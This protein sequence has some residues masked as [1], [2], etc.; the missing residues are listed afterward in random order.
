MPNLKIALDGS[1]ML[2]VK[3]GVYQYV[4]NL[5]HSLRHLDAEFELNYFLGT[6][7]SKNLPDL[8]N[9]IHTSNLYKLI[10]SSFNVFGEPGKL[11][12]KNIN[13]IFQK[14]I[15]HRGIKNINPHI[16]HFTDNYI[17]ISDIPTVYTFYDLS[18]FRFPET[19]PY[20]RVVWQEKQLPKALEQ[21]S[22]IIAISEFSKNELV[23]Y[24]GIN[25]D[26]I[27]VIYCGVNESFYPL[28]KEEV[29]TT[30]NNFSLQYKKYILSLGTIEPRKNLETIIQAYTKLPQSIQ[31]CYKMVIVGAYG[32]KQ[33]NILKKYSNLIDSGNLVI[34]GYMDQKFLPSIISGAAL[35]AYPS[36]YEGFGLPVLES[37]ACGTPVISSNCS[38][39]PEILN[40]PDILLNPDDTSAWTETM[41]NIL[42][43]RDYSEYLSKQGVI[44]AKDFSWNSC[45]EKTFSTY[46]K[47]AHLS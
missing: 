43:D 37:M 18:C 42:N 36:R 16:I 34:L 3:A 39:M 14:R 5:C 32:W 10:N 20:S 19:H 28:D 8:N 41:K 22:H 24:F 31:N 35:V 33:S 1:P 30:L 2:G 45:A 13:Y 27:S 11:V 44:R 9:T 26:R 15:F 4:T 38:S 46:S 40:N 12:K 47:V 7:W 23:S 21:S 17:C 29:I 6:S 25:P